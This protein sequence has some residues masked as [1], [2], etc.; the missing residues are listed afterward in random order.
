MNDNPHISVTTDK[1]PISYRVGEEMRF[2]FS[3][4]G[5]HS[6]RWTITGDDGR[7][8]RGS[9]PCAA[10]ARVVQTAGLSRPGFVRIVAELLDEDG[11][12]LASFN[13]GAG[14]AVADIRQ[15]NPEPADFDAFWTRRKAAL[16]AVPMDGATC[17]EIESG[18]DDVHLYEVSIPCAG[19]RPSTGLLSIPVACGPFP[20]RAHFHGYQES[21]RPSAYN[22]PAPG[23]LST[24]E[25]VLDV[26]SHGFEFNREPEYYAALRAESGSKSNIDLGIVRDPEGFN[27]FFESSLKGFSQLGI[28]EQRTTEKSNMASDRAAAGK[29]CDR[30][31]NNRLED[32]SC[33]VFFRRAFIDEWLKVTL[34]ENTA[35]G[36]DRVE[37]RIRFS[38]LV[39]TIGIYT[40]KSC[41]LV[42][43]STCTAG[44][45]T[46]HTLFRNRMQVS[47]LRILTAKFDDNIRL[48][49]ILRNS[50]GFRNNFLYKIKAQPLRNGKSA[51][52]GDLH[53]SLKAREFLIYFFKRIQEFSGNIRVVSSI[54][55]IDHFFPFSDY[56][57]DRRRAYIQAHILYRFHEYPSFSL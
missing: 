26:S 55:G 45:C 27:L 8:E 28:K 1:D 10:C 7:E 33:K 35:S 29:T 25:I 11:T 41:H 15:D 24:T 36:C 22:S 23:A 34:G 39:Q 16:A 3:S 21:W 18:R 17:R 20:A 46:I 42:D 48:R 5:G 6:L 52:T 53:T 12:V 49:V 47:D 50:N 56:D 44:T 40:K 2:T 43:K 57:L 32:R 51:G 19:G 37:C 14:A 13:G 38:K 54:L 30:L 31:V 9:A 4:A